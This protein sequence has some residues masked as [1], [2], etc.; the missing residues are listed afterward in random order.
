MTVSEAL[1]EFA[2]STYEAAA[3]LARRDRAKLDRPP[4]LETPV[5]AHR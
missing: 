2:Q 1:L 3:D 4:S 5:A